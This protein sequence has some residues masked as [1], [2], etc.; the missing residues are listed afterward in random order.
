MQRAQLGKYAHEDR[1]PDALVSLL[2]KGGYVSAEGMKAFAISQG[3]LPL[4]DT[5]FFS[6]RS[7]S[8]SGSAIGAMLLDE[9]CIPLPP[10]CSAH[11]E[12][13]ERRCLHYQP[14]AYALL[15]IDPPG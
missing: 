5:L 9:I 1:M 8:G 11:L 2:R 15:S 3:N 13:E 7:G 6:D 4:A 14:A 10:K 12:A